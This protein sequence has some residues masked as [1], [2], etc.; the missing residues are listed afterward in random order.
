MATEKRLLVPGSGGHHGIGWE[1]VDRATWDGD[2]QLLTI[3]QSAPPGLSPRQHRLRVEDAA[4]LLDV[5][6][7]LPSRVVTAYLVG[8]NPGC[9]LLVDLLAG[10]RDPVA[11]E[12]IAVKY[13]TCGTAVLEFDSE[14][15]ALTPRSARLTVF[16]VPRG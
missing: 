11:A 3:T 2:D 12:A 4:Q 6:R 15:A 16:A 8:H 9:E 5:V 1:S 7:E 13:P 10:D 14:W